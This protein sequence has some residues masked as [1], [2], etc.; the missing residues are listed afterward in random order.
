M[1]SRLQIEIPF[2]FNV[3]FIFTIQPGI[4]CGVKFLMPSH[5]AC[6]DYILIL[7]VFGYS[8]KILQDSSKELYRF[9]E[10]LK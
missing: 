7:H 1:T 5:S 4:L 6:I 10:I 3:Q 9:E 8:V 2:H